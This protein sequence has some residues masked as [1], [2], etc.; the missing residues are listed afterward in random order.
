MA[1]KL[2]SFDVNARLVIIAGITIK[3]ESYEDALEQSKTL[4]E[5]DFV[6]VL[7][8]FNDGSLEIGSIAKANYWRTDD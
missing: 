6:K 1:K 7:G 4:R 5:T 2:D 8:E 3:A